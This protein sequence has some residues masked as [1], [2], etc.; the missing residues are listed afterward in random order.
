MLEKSFHQSLF[1]FFF[2]Y[3]PVS[4]RQFLDSD[5]G[6]SL[7]D[8]DSLPGFVGASLQ[9]QFWTG[10]GRHHRDLPLHLALRTGVAGVRNVVCQEDG[11]K[12]QRP[13]RVPH[14]ENLSE[15]LSLPSFFLSCSG[16]L[17]GVT[18]DFR[19]LLCCRKRRLFLR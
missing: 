4:R 11:R 18:F 16:F 1:F 14:V 19:S 3:V 12:R 13:V 8:A 9:D 10:S 7:V 15:V 6:R 5:S 17:T 2:F